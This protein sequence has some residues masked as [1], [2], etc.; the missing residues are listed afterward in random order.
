[1]AKK[2]IIID[3]EEYCVEV[4]E[5]LLQAHHSNIQII[6][7]ANS[8]SDGLKKI[9]DLKPDLVFLDIQMPEMNGFELLEKCMPLNFAVIFTTAFDSHAIK[10]IKYSALDYLLKPIGSEDLSK[11]LLRFFAASEK[12]NYSAQYSLLKESIKSVA[13]VVMQRIAIPSADALEMLLIAE[14]MLCEASGSYTLI[15]SEKT[16]KIL[17]SKYL[18][19]YEDILESHGFM[20]IHHSYLVNVNFI[21]R[22]IKGDGGQVVLLNDLTLPVSRSK[23]D[24]LVSLLQNPRPF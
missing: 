6:A 18:K 19:E 3:D 23:K 21:K 8:A 4:L 7:T 24:A 16:G 15:H 10:A 13:P 1:M 9:V 22:Y 11:A 17:S 5:V 2:A 14:I 20:R 12:A